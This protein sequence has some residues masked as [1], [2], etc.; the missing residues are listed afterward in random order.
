MQI[1]IRR[2]LLNDLLSYDRVETG[3][4]RLEVGTVHIWDV[5][6]KTVGQF[7]IQATNRKLNLDFSIRGNCLEGANGNTTYSDQSEIGEIV[8]TNQE[9]DIEMGKSSGDHS[10]GFETD[11]TEEFTKLCVI[12]DDMRLSQVLRNLLSNA[13]KFTPE[14]GTITVTACHVVNGL[15]SSSPLELPGTNDIQDESKEFQEE[16]SRA[17]SIR[18]M[19]KDDGAGMTHDQLKM[20]FNEGVQ[21]DANKLQ[22]GGG[23]GLGLFITKGIVEQHGGAIT[24][25]SEGPGLGCLFVVDL[26]LFR[27]PQEDLGEDDE[28]D[29]G[30][31]GL[32]HSTSPTDAPLKQNR[33]ILVVDDALMNRKMLV[34][35][36]ERAGHTCEAATNGREAIDAYVADKEKADKDSSHDPFDTILIDFEMPVLNGPDATRILR[37]MGCTASIFGVTG[38]VLDEDVEYFKSH[39]ANEVLP[40]P[41]NMALLDQYWA[42]NAVR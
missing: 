36:L 28:T 2:L 14:H 25:M 23:S 29:A 7:Q 31:E 22:A 13:L 16:H 27:F 11:R 30:T 26:P 24:A 20:L 32:S 18:I 38:N 10:S 42:R 6:C 1:T 8:T 17:G 35:I 9:C 19:V 33:R 21:F 4:L 41:V 37:D 5:V 3:T 12:G 40:K 15:P 39:G 34:R